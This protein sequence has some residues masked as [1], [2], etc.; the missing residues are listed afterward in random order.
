[1]TRRRL[2]QQDLRALGVSHGLMAHRIGPDG[3][4]RLEQLTPEASGRPALFLRPGSN[5]RS[6][7]QR[8]GEAS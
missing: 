2:S 8:K 4:A 3:R 7:E 6:T 1:M 5:G